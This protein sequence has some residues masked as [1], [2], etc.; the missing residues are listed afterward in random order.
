MGSVR[1]WLRVIITWAAKSRAEEASAAYGSESVRPGPL[2]EGSA[3]ITGQLQHPGIAPVYELSQRN[4]AGD[5][6]YTMRFINGRTLTEA[7][8]DYHH[9]RKAGEAQCSNCVS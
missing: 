6:F 5:L 8:R 3:V 7:V 2:L 9:R 4:Q 1:V